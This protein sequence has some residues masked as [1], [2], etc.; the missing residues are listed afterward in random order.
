MTLPAMRV[1]VVD[2]ELGMLEVC[3]D[4]LAALSDVE[5][6]TEQRSNV[7]VQKLK[8]HN[9]DLLIADIRMP[10]VGGIELLEITRRNDPELPVLLLTAYPTVQT[11]VESMKL[12][13]ADY[14]VKPFLPDDLR[15]TVNR[16]LRERRLR[17]EN[18][19]LRQQVERT[20]AFGEIV[21]R[22][23]PMC[24]V[25][26]A[27]D[28]VAATDVDVLV[29][30]ETGT[31]KELVARRIHEQGNRRAGHFVPI[32][33][34]AIPEDLL[35]S[36]FFGH[37]RGAFT[38]A[39]A[40]RLGLLEFAARGTLFLDEIDHLPVR[41]QAKLLRVLQ[42]R[43]I[44]RVGG[45]EEFPVDLRIVAA[46]SA[47]LEEEVRRQSFRPDLYY[48]INVARIDVP[49]LRW[50]PEDIGPL[51]AHFVD[52]YAHEIGRDVIEVDPEALEVL[53]SYS[54][55]G[56]VRELQNVIK[57]V[58]VFSR[59]PIIR[60]DNLPEGVVAAAGAAPSESRGFFAL[61]EQHTASF[62]RT[63]LDQLLRAHGG[64]VAAAA[65][66]ARVPRGTLYRLLKNHG[67]SATNFRDG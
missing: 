48:R 43:R 27:I 58:L 15:A 66:E 64:D 67:F 30:G 1:L 5:V 59:Q 26:D 52:R 14:I 10:G 17:E 63:Y 19:L 42:E 21:G 40:R 29:T 44:R 39:S 18:V 22:S 23:A 38:G 65:V 13:A 7:A 45:T 31:G 8:E 25:L 24:A 11:A 32:D 61:R 20:Y 16:I 35:E 47:D 49:P 60:V 51:V 55:P 3:R 2:D 33:C 36:E 28:R 34:G 50:R 12:G 4:T 56:N 41:L 62:E 57:R 37:E 6:V 53:T 54:W 46:T 9:W